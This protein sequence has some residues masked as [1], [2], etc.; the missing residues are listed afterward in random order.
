MKD[1][2]IIIR[3]EK[4]LPDGGTDSA[5][6]TGLIVSE[7]PKFRGVIWPDSA[8]ITINKVPIEY[9]FEVLDYPLAKAK[10]ALRRMGKTFGIT[11]A[12]REALQS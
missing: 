9:K 10:R 11:K 5:I 2:I 12:A 8:G 3:T 7:G 6:R 1:S 4:S